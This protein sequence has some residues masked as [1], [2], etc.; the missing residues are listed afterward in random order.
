M[1]GRGIQVKAIL[2][3]RG[4]APMNPE[5]N[6][7]VAGFLPTLIEYSLTS[8]P[9]LNCLFAAPVPSYIGLRV[10][11]LLDSLASH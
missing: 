5:L 9:I 10:Q 7:E 4:E 11:R 2:E 8:L 3:S 6:S 1:V